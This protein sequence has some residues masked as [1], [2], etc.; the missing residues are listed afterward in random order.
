MRIV[1]FGATG[2]TGRELVRQS[3]AAG[4][5][6]AAVARHKDAALASAGA[7][8]E[9]IGADVTDR[10]SVASIVPGADAVLSA[11]GTRK[12]N[13]ATTV[14]STGVTNILA[15]MRD[16]DV[17]RFIAISALPVGA[18]HGLAEHVIFPILYRFF[19]A[20]Y[21]DMK[22]ME[23]ILEVSDC[24]WT[25]FRPPQLANRA[26]TGKYRTAIDAPLAG[27]WRLTRADLA[28]AMV[29]AISD[30]ALVRQIVTIS[31]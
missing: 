4:Y 26:A 28:A 8:V 3:A 23:A 24:D 17:R 30:S 15:A 2:G 31:S 7:S 6:V 22:R 11:L 16:A 18:P 27:A 10:A 13:K 19:G 14:Y 25:V 12:L 21:E 20:A 29:A 9:F 1:I 5:A